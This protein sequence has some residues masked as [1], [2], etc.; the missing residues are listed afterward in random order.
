MTSQ[1][2][3]TV[4]VTPRAL[5]YCFCICLTSVVAAWALPQRLTAST[6]RTRLTDAAALSHGHGNTRCSQILLPLDSRTKLANILESEQAHVGVEVGVQRGE[7]AQTM[8]QSWSH[9]T[10]YYLVDI[11]APLDNYLDISNVG[12]LFTQM[13]LVHTRTT[14]GVMDPTLFVPCCF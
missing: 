13:L 6:P 5:L 4:S 1:A 8:L 9:N 2:G 12:K 11:W 14:A 7:F 10:K 3:L